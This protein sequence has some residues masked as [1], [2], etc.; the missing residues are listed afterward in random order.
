M[1]SRCSQ[2]CRKSKDNDDDDFPSSCS[3]KAK[4]LLCIS[5][6]ELKIIK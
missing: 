6:L 4:P 1:C 3:G 5:S 2:C